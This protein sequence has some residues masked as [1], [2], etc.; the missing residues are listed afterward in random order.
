[1]TIQELVL[2]IH[3]ACGASALI[4]GPVAMWARKAPGLHTRFGEIYHW[5][6]VGILITACTL[7]FLNWQRLWWFV[8]VAI[9]SYAFALLGY[10]SAKLR[11]NNWLRFHLTGQGG[12]YIAMTTAV[13]IVNVGTAS[14][15][16]WIL[17]TIIGSPVIA[18]ITREV[19]LGR[20]PKYT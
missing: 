20:R 11:W 16:A 4:V 9:G 19:S 6:F 2:A 7:A 8:P 3:I 14:W 5:L 15:W 1:M 18:W 17:P 10:L 12:S 13:L